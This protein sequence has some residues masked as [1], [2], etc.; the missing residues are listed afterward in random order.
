MFGAITVNEI[1]ESFNRY[2][3]RNFLST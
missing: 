1:E 3:I 2:S